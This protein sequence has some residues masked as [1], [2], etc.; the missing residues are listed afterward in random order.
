MPLPVYKPLPL[1]AEAGAGY[2]AAPPLPVIC[3]QQWKLVQVFVTNASKTLVTRRFPPY[4]EARLDVR[5]EGGCG[6]GLEVYWGWDW[7]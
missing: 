2:P 5:L 7:G 6:V 1:P 4:M 3:V